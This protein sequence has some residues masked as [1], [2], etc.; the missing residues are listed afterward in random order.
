MSKT[1]EIPIM[2]KHL[3][4]RSGLKNCIKKCITCCYCMLSMIF[5]GEIRIIEKGKEIQA[6]THTRTHTHTHIY[7]QPLELPP[8]TNVLFFPK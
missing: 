2:S 4:Q 7:I 1:S 8:K 3:S 6:Y 5:N